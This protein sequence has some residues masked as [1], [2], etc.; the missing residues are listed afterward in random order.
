MLLDHT[1]NA[2]I[3]SSR[4]VRGTSQRNFLTEAQPVAIIALTSTIYMSSVKTVAS[5]FKRMFCEYR[6]QSELVHL[7]VIQLNLSV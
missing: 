1:T 3:L 5:A 6:P 7:H 2:A 4:A